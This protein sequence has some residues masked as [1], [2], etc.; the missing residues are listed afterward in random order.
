MKNIFSQLFSPAERLPGRSFLRIVA[1]MVMAGLLHACGG[2][3]STE[4]NPL[5][6][7]NASNVGTSRYNGPNP[8]SQD[9][10]EFQSNFW[11][12]AYDENA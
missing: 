11:N 1:V 8:A 7:S 6:S 4:S 5:T 9:V 2:G 10:I 12:P 3:A